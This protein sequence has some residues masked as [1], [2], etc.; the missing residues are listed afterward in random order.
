MTSCAGYKAT[1]SQMFTFLAPN[2]SVTKCAILALTMLF[3]FIA[4]LIQLLVPPPPRHLKC[5]LLFI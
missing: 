2:S 3:P 4:L 5:I 1:N